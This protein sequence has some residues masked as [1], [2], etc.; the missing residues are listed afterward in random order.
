[1]QAKSTQI[2]APITSVILPV[3]NGSQYLSATLS[4]ILS[5]SFSDFEL[6]IINDG[7]S[8]DSESVIKSFNDPRIKYFSQK[9]QGLPATLNRAI[10]LAQGEFVA[11]Q[12]QDDLSFPL[13]L[14]KQVEFLTKNPDVGMVGTN[15]EIWEN[16]DKTD[17]LLEH[18]SDD[19]TIKFN[20]LFNNPFVHS[21]VVVRRNVFEKV[22]LYCEDKSRQ[23]PE[24]YELWSRVARK[25]KMAN[26]PDVLLAYREVPNSMSRSGVNPFLNRLITISAENI[27]FYSGSSIENPEVMATAKL[28][29]GV[30]EGIP[31][32]V[33]FSKI[34]RLV[35]N[36][37]KTLVG[38]SNKKSDEMDSFVT[39]RLAML[40]YHYFQYKTGGR[41]GKFMTS[42]LLRYPKSVLKRIIGR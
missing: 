19:A 24:D 25:C 23:P 21:S 6:I 5:Q 41:F 29:H 34:K 38:N 3:Y 9:N 22:G 31:R 13:R 42:D 14:E 40:R 2:D 12:D 18:P 7:S 33:D 17:R 35:N 8:D 10:G 36:A 1:M 20:L 15:A 27:A 26:L 11:R 4:A 37:A 16:N 32:G 30:Y 28:A 39:L